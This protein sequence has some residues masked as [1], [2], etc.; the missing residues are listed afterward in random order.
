MTLLFAIPIPKEA[1]Y[2]L[3]RFLVVQNRVTFSVAA[4]RAKEGLLFIPSASS[5]KFL[6]GRL[7]SALF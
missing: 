3:G 2:S 4:V 7:Y 5:W 6:H 1:P